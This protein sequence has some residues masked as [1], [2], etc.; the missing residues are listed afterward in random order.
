M[1]VDDANHRDNN[2]WDASAEAWI[3]EQGEHGDFGRRFVLDA[4]MLSRVEAGAYQRVLDIGCGEGRFCRLLSTRGLRVTGIDPTRR[5]IDRAKQVDPNGDYR[6]GAAE[7]L[8]FPDASVDLALGYLTLIDIDDHE[9]AIREMAR[10]VRPGGGV[11]I[12]N[13]TG[14]TSSQADQGWVRDADNR[15][16]HYPVD[17]YLETRPIRSAW[18]GIDVINWHRPLGAYMRAFIDAGL[19]LTHFDEPAPH[20]GPDA[21][22]DRYRRVPLYVIMEWE[23]PL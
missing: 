10:V 19:R 11:L 9:A 15:P 12:A 8:D 7:R 6:V 3:A 20:G 2:G 1:T 16:I 17:R 5:L 14:F 18:R 4:P 13:L 22:A 23:K 21:K